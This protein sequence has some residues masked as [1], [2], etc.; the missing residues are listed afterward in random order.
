M[1]LLDFKGIKNL[2]GDF[3]N[4]QYEVKKFLGEGSFAKVYLVNHNYLDDLRAMKIIKEPISPTTNIKSVFKEVMLATKLRHENIISIY[5]AG[6]MSAYNSGNNQDLAFFV[7]EYVPGGDLE[8]YLNSFIDS[9]LSMPIDRALNLIR[10]ILMGLNTL[11]LSNP[12]II[13]RDLKLNN[14]LLSYDANGDITVKISDFGFSKEVTTKISDIDIVGTRPYMAPECFRKV[15]STMTD[16]YAVGVIFYQ[17]LTNRFPYGI[18]KFNVEELYD[19]KPW[20]CRLM[21]P[22]HYN[23]NVSKSL[24]SIVMKCL[25]TDPLERYHNASELLNDVEIAISQ[26]PQK[27]ENKIK[28]KDFDYYSDYLINDSLKKAF[29]LA[30]KENGLNEAIEI[31]EGEVLKHYDVRE[32]YGETLRMWKSEYPDVKLVSRAFTVNLRGKN[33]QLSCDLLKEA[34]SYN[35]PIKHKYVHYI[36]LWKI[37]I[38]L[39]E[40]GN[41]VKAVL[42][43]EEL[44]D[45][46]SHINSIYSSIISILKTFSIEEIVSQ[47]VNLVKLN[48]LVDASNLM[49]FAVVLDSNIRDEYEYRLS[50]WKQNINSEFGLVKSGG[51]TVDYAIDLGTTDSI[52][53]YY[54]DGKPVIIKNHKTGED[55]TPSAVRI[56]EEN[57]IH[58]GT[59]ARD[60][61]LVDNKNAV[62]E[63]KHNMGFSIPFNFQNASRVMQPEELSAEILKD[64]RISA[65]EQFGVDLNHAVICVPAN[66]N[67]MKTRAI[68]DAADIA[69]FRSHSLLMEHAAVAIAYDLASLGDGQWLIYDFGGG[70]FSLSL[71]SGNSGDIEI[72]DSL[73]LDDFGGNAIDWAI[74]NRVFAP[75]ISGDLNLE[76]FNDSNPKYKHIFS[77]LKVV[78]ENSKKELSK[79]DSTDILV[80]DLFTNYDFNCNLTQDMLEEIIESLIKPTFN[81]VQNLLKRHSVESHEID[82]VILVGG[83]CI[84]PIV[85]KSIGEN[86]N[87]P[88]EFSINPLTVVAKGA[89]IYAGFLKTPEIDIVSYPPCLI[90]DIDDENIGGRVFSIDDKLSFLGYYIEFANENYSTGKIPLSIDGNFKVKI[91]KGEYKINLY[92]NDSL[93]ELDEKSPDGIKNNEMHI[94]FFNRSFLISDDTLVREDIIN[95]YDSLVS[96]I[97]YLKNHSRSIGSAEILDYV[98]RLIDLIQID[99]RGLN[100]ASIFISYLKKII[101]EE[102]A[103][104]NFLI[105]LKNVENKVSIV[106]Q[107]DLFDVDELELR[108]NEVK[109][110]G[111]FEKLEEIYD[112]LMETYV[113]LNRDEVII[114]CFFNLKAEGIYS[115]NEELYEKLSKKASKALDSH[116]FDKLAEVMIALYEIDE[117]ISDVGP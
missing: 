111:D 108:L 87:I 47:S 1:V 67:Y 109:Q 13:H 103:N 57:N 41:L 59:D 98:D 14:I 35:P 43:L 3:F 5:D 84:S 44:M 22:S 73:R 50:L 58:V 83:S 33:Y 106:K 107:L 62:S 66:S 49:E 104:L 7:M 54:N 25:K 53:S 85:Q 102:T 31:L 117:R 99:E 9:N 76:N 64:L 16:I 88:L 8:Q 6:I 105:L 40:D 42:S 115:N 24:D 113:M 74:V 95:Q 86:L 70:T 28:N 101:D 112:A 15:V 4:G 18:E 23:K 29:W 65:Y 75:K 60:V 38:E 82:K 116:D 93:V 80:N 12:P 52:L 97:D 27:T 61:L 26:L 30:K 36:D 79:S 48:N 34:I 2:V 77:T 10:Q 11:H 68:N 20:Q 56:D 81:L 63:F 46:N 94:E 69:G 39:S 100:L 21:P 71:I 89:S 96:S 37:F 45:S 32:L 114:S 90:L 17:L 72:V 55:F 110:T 51:Y 92:K 19:L 78:A 91:K